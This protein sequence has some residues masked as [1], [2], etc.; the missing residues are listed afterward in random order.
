M[1]KEKVR[2]LAIQRMAQIEDQFSDYIC[3]EAQSYYLL[4]F[5]IVNSVRGYT[6]AHGLYPLDLEACIQGKEI[7]GFGGLSFFEKDCVSFLNQIIDEQESKN[8]HRRSISL[9]PNYR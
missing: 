7:C 4:Q 3:P 1:T 8:Q 9:V 5:L 2:Q 6:E